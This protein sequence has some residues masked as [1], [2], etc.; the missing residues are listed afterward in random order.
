VRIH[1]ARCCALRMGLVLRLSASRGTCEDD[2]RRGNC[3][4]SRLQNPPEYLE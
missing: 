1:L 4:L 3:I 2:L